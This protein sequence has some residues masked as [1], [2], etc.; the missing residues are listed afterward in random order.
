MDEGESA[1]QQKTHDLSPTHSEVVAMTL[2]SELQPAIDI[3]VD[4][5]IV[6]LALSA[7]R[8]LPLEPP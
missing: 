2:L 1:A 4:A 3:A 6:V 5:A 7:V 8:P